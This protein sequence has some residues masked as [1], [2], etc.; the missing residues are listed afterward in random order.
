MKTIHIEAGQVIVAEGE[1][2]NDAYI[3]LSGEIEVTK[4]ALENSFWFKTGV[5]PMLRTTYL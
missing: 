5:V 2:T 1:E 4:K 3:I